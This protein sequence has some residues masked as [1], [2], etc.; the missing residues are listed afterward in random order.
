MGGTIAIQE[1]DTAMP[2]TPKPF[3]VEIAVLPETSPGHALALVELLRT[4]NL[5]ARLRLGTGAPRLG[6]RFI[7]AQAQPLRAEQGLLQAVALEGDCADM[8]ADALFI[9]S[10]HLADIPAIRQAVR[11]HAALVR[12]VALMADT[13]RRVCTQ[14]N[15]AWFAAGSGR[16]DHSRVALAWYYIAAMGRDF[17]GI[18]PETGA[19][20]CEDGAWL[21]AA[22]PGDLGALASALTRL[23]LGIEAADALAAVLRPD[24]DRALAALQA[25]HTIP[26]TRDSTL[27]RAIAW[28]EQRVEQPYDLAA[29]A[30]AAAVSAR[31]L[32]RHF[33]QE[34]GHS[35]LDHLHG[36]RCAR[37]RVLLE[38]TLESVPT[39]ALACG[40]S[41]PAAFR[42]IFARHTGQTPTA[43]RQ[44]HA[45]RAPRR[46]W[47]VETGANADAALAALRAATQKPGTM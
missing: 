26:N 16:L 13:D 20:F 15:A 47:R 6:W 36:L 9:A 32:L 8:P 17:P 38:I 21:S 11:R 31:T 3:V 2:A 42:R 1:A 27:A 41:D 14:G 30:T 5:L 19:G 24:R 43:Y 10:L 22:Y 23:A 34:L 25:V 39:V 12:R 44:R 4:A 40:Y 7:D 46:R 33:K 28:M 35:P 45:L 18:A 37:A 29:L